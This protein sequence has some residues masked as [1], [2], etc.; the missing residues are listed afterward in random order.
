[1]SKIKEVISIYMIEGHC[2][3][4]ETF[5]KMCKKL[6][7]RNVKLLKYTMK[8]V[9]YIKDITYDYRL[10][11]ESTEDISEITRYAYEIWDE[12]GDDYDFSMSVYEENED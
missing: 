8:E 3:N 9:C 11:V 6:I 12:I 1:M 10:Y 2:E 4:W 5:T 7:D